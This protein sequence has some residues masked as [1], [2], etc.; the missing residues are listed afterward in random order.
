MSTTFC[1]RNKKIKMDAGCNITGAQYLRQLLESLGHPEG[2]LISGVGSGTY[3]PKETA[4]QWGMTILK[5]LEEKKIKHL[6][7]KDKHMQGG[8]R[9]IPVTEDHLTELKKLGKMPKSVKLVELDKETAEWLEHTGK[10][11]MVCGGFWQW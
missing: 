2:V 4:T 1:P 10:F 7:I 11:F 5:G 8:Y 9:D 3:I 6:K